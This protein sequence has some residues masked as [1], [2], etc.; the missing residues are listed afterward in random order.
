MLFQC[1]RILHRRETKG[2]DRRIGLV[3]I[4]VSQAKK[5]VRRK[6][7][8]GYPPGCLLPGD[9]GPGP[10]DDTP[11]NDNSAYLGSIVTETAIRLRWIQAYAKE[12]ATT[13]PILRSPDFILT[14]LQY[15]SSGAKNES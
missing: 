10:R 1:Y 4:P 3:L 2:D 11:T 13:P 15:F 7:T 6:D 8:K 12:R 5:L 14:I 9:G